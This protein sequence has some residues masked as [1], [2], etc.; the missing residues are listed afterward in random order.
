[1]V[2]VFPSLRRHDPDQVLR[3]GPYWSLSALAGLPV[4]LMD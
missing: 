1:M 4:F 2:H 3:V